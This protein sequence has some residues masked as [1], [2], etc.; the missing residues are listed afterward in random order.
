M[1]I[2]KYEQQG[3]GEGYHHSWSMNPQVPKNSLENQAGYGVKLQTTTGSLDYTEGS[4]SNYS[5]Q[6][7]TF[8]SDY[9]G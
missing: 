8:P 4:K 3:A 6:I 2:T 1:T 9:F 7:P 5:E